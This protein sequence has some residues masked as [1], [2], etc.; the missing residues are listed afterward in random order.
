MAT[1]K[2][3]DVYVEEISIFPPSVAEVE[4]AIPAF[5]GYTQ[6]AKKLVDDDL[7]NMP[8]RISSMLD[9]ENYFGYGPAVSVSEV[10][11]DDNGNF[12]SSTMSTIFY[13][14]D[15]LRLFYANG[16]G[17]CY[18]VSV[19]LYEDDAVELGVYANDPTAA[20]GLLG[21]LG[22]IEM[23][24][25]PTII[26]Y[27]DAVS[28]DDAAD[29]Y[30]SL[31]AQTLGLCNKLKDR[32]GLFDL[33]RDDPTGTDFRNNIGINYLKYGAAYTPWL[34]VSLPKNIT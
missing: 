14:Y 30:G 20:Q 31:Q 27:P 6:A 33:L 28:L 13:M 3:P 32:V 26:L 24:D 4:T 23:Y 18:I 5:I 19:G 1:Y 34:K 2:T 8:T 17:D 11:I 22:M 9:F 25:E 10:I 15:S 7:V 12:K 21:G 16:G 29:L